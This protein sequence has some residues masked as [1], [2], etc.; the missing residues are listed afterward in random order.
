MLYVRSLIA[1]EKTQVSGTAFTYKMYRSRWQ[2]LN[3]LPADTAFLKTMI[4]M[5]IMVMMIT[6]MAATTTKKM[7]P[8]P[9]T[10]GVQAVRQIPFAR[11]KNKMFKLLAF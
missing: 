11:H 1:I 3:Q 6:M 4:M 2:P 5:R 8:V 10:E 7:V 9:D